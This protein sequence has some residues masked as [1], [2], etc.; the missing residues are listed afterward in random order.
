M[1]LF[2]L[3]FIL[4]FQLQG[5]ALQV[6]ASS[7]YIRELPSV[8][9]PIV[10]SVYMND[11]LIA[12]GRNIDGNW[13]QATRLG[14]PIGWI[15][16][17]VVTFT[18]DPV[19]LPLTDT[20]TGLIGETPIIDT[21]FS[22]QT[23]NNATL[24][25]EPERNAAQRL[26]L[27]VFSVV[28]VLERTPDNQWLYVNYLG[29]VGWIQQFLTYSTT[30][31]DS[32]PM[33]VTYGND[34][35]FPAVITIPPET[36]LA[37][38]DRLVAY[39]TPLNTLAGGVASYWRGIGNGE[40]L[41]CQPLNADVE[42]YPISEQD[43][44]ELPELRQQEY[45]LREAVESLNAALLPTQECGILFGVGIGDAY[46]DALNARSIFTLITRRMESLRERIDLT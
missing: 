22:V 43:L 1:R 40:I 6:K 25:A 13:L 2:M 16:R 4:F 20:T 7:A 44:V 31:L 36:Q 42:Y 30:P 39:M 19:L 38:I 29:T 26:I 3:S 32:I 10:T 9:A 35:R 14:Q 37:Q 45:R 11:S 21:G 23:L 17:N 8:E 18:F 15:S 28:P 12:I 33:S 34:P 5:F 27:P 46:A 41:E 24:Y